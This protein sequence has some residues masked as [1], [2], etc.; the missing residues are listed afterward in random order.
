MSPEIFPDVQKVDQVCELFKE[1]EWDPRE[2]VVS[3][4]GAYLYAELLAGTRCGPGGGRRRVSVV[5]KD[6]F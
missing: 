5:C 4:S 2:Q 1:K 3:R 6:L